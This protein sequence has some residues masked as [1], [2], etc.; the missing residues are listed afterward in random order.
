M[1]NRLTDTLFQLMQTLEKAEKRHF[2]LYIKRSSANEDLKI[3][4]LFDALDTM[5]EYDEDRLMKK[6][7]PITKTQL[8]NLKTHLYKQLLAS[9]RLLKTTDNVD[10]QLSEHLDNARLLYNKGLKIQSLKILEKAKEVARTN[11]KFNFLV[12]AISLEKKIETLHITRS[13]TD[14]TQQMAAE[15]TEVSE[16]INRVTRL[17]NL[18]LLLYRWYVLNGHARNEEDE[19]N[20]KAYFKEQLPFDINAVNGFYEK[21]YLYQSYSWYGFIRQNFLQYY[22]Y[23]QK[24]IDLFTEQPFLLEIETGHY[25][26]GMHNLLNA[27]FDLRNF[28]QFDNTLKQFEAFAVSDAGRRHD[29][30]RTHTSIYINSARINYHLMKGTFNEGVKLVPEI[31]SKLKE[32]SLYVDRH[33]ILVFTYKFASLYFGSGDYNKAIDYLMQIINGPLDLRMDLQC[34]ARLMHLMAH[35]E[36]GNDEI[37][38]SLTKS[39]YRFMSKMKNLTVVEEE[40][41][42]FLRS[43]FSLSPKQ[44]KPSLEKFLNKIKHLEKNRFE[45]R[46]YAYL[47]IVSWVES[48]VENKPMSEVIY[49]KYLKS[50]HR[51]K[52]KIKTLAAVIRIQQ[53]I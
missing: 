11:Q 42:K 37:I 24:W 30:F 46:A 7:N 43:A 35:Y 38:E 36:L 13:T 18:A 3:I 22:R 6:L 47:D 34:Y 19:K 21:L 28:K 8:A 39:V 27:H 12:Q 41:F 10:L 1:S 32:Y 4:R 5:P 31:E 51:K 2:K 9:L 33:R 52:E 44:L 14:K 20:I 16:H 48:K 23:S 29:N 17:S 26:K 15:A 45:T 49:Q 53:I 50:R 25:I 40:M